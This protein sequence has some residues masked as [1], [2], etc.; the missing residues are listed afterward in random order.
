MRVKLLS[1][2]MLWLSFSV[3][4][5]EYFPKNDGVKTSKNSYTAFTNAKIYV[6]PTEVLENATLLIQKGKV[7]AAGTSIEVPDNSITI[8]LEGKYIYPSFIDI[9]SEFGVE[10]PKRQR[11]SGPQYDASRK[12]YYWNDHIIPDQDAVN[13]FKFDTNKAK[14]LVEN[15]FGVVNTHIA[16]GIVR[17]SG[18][19][20]A[21][22]SE[23]NNSERILE[24]KSSQFLSFDKSA[25]SNQSYPTSLMG[26]MAL[27][28]QLYHDADWYAKGNADNKDMAIEALIK[29]QE[30]PQ[31]FDAGN[32]KL[33]ALRANK[34]GNEF[35]IKY[36]IKG[37][38]YE[39]ERIDEIKNLNSPLII[40]LNF[41]NAYDVTDPYQASKVSLSD[42]RQWNQ[43]PTNLSV[44]SS[45]NISFALT[46]AENKKVSEF[47]S[48]LMKA[49]EYGLAPEI[50][51]AA[52]TEV[53]AKL[54]GKSDEM[55]SL[56]NGTHANF[57]ITSGPLFEKSTTL[58][59]NWVQGQKHIINNMNIKDIRGDY[60]LKVNG[61]EY[62]LS[63]KGKI[64]S[65]SIEI[66]KD[67]LKIASKLEYNNGW[68]NVFFAPETDG[69]KTYTRLTT[70]VTKSD[71]LNGSGV[72]ANGTSVNWYATKTSDFESKKKQDKNEVQPKVFPVSFPNKA[73][74]FKNTPQQETILFKN[75]TVWTNENEGVLKNTDVLVKNGKIAEIGTSLSSNEARVIDATGKHLT[76]GII[77]EHSHIAADAIN[78]AGHNSSAEVNIGDVVNPDDINI[79]RNLSG[80]V[81]TIQILHGSANPIGGRSALIKL[82]WGGSAEDMLIDNAPKFIKF[83]LGENVKQSNWGTTQT[84]RFPQT[85]MGVEQVFTDYF[86]RAKEYKESWNNYNQ[87]SR[88]AK[89]NSKAPR[90]DIEMETIAEIINK[91]RFISCH[92]YVQSEINM[93][94]KVADNFNFNVNTF[95]HILEGYKVADK[96][97]EHGVGGSTF[98]DW[99][100]YKYEVKDAIPYNAA[101]MHDAGVT[102]A[103]NSDDAEMSRRLNQEA[104]KTIKYGGVSEEDAWKFVTLNPAKLLH[105]DD[106]IGSIKKGKDA[107]LVLWSDHPLSIYAI[108]EKTMIEGTVYYDYETMQEMQNSINT[109][110]NE[111]INMMIAA[112]NNGMKT[113]APVK[114]EEKHF[115]CDSL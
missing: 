56:K 16:D 92:S 72:L 58:Y 3:F 82:K 98:S 51:L 74:G 8:N 22:N 85:R 104:A 13:K 12:G 40:P 50:A 112:K 29:N 60:N 47:K 64:E 69:S 84:I 39:Y 9:Y 73:Y 71:N 115:H 36:I 15:G 6:T 37:S 107:D 102:V 106:R 111:L 25:A 105:L 53:P 41:P 96:M 43:A 61:T 19:L 97:V 100:A 30:L 35:D 2:C 77:D 26:A 66:K 52:L 70:K 87:L 46:T 101:I 32:N 27:L 44:L 109:E 20:V 1:L 81:T 18:V 10:K 48:N 49:I 89:A 93:L 91:E 28:R 7:I 94:M 24:Q 67:T 80:G 11:S 79:Y 114:K 33:N 99:W 76:T 65:P 55:G 38:G 63:I 78:E 103:I 5:Q 86:Q 88:R 95:T 62:N 57:L 108:A 23:A 4:S 45:N 83:A 17:G 21:L 34:I 42:M 59:E 68:V 75:A 31:I 54:L 14:E 90:Y 113:Q 110:R